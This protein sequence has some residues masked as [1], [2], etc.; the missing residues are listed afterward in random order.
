ML[1]LILLANIKQRVK[2]KIAT[3]AKNSPMQLCEQFPESIEP[4]ASSVYINSF[5]VVVCNLITC[6][7]IALFLL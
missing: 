6:N 5:S 2:F 4:R 1:K 7:M 3:Y